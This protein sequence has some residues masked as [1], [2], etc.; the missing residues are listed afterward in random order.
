MLWGASA[1]ASRR[2]G[3]SGCSTPFRRALARAAR[4]APA[5]KSRAQTGRYPSFAAAMAK[6]PEPVPM[7][8]NARPSFREWRHGGFLAIS[9]KQKAVVGCWPV[10]KLNPGSRMTTA[11]FF[12]AFFLLHPGLTSSKSSNS[13][14]LKC[15]FHDSAQSSFRTRP[16]ETLAGP[17]HKATVADSVQPFPEFFGAHSGRSLR[18]YKHQP[19]LCPFR[20]R[21]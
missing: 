15:R 18:E 12:R 11:W 20:S 17:N 16:I 19:G 8:R 4:T 9:L 10:P 1:I 21:K 14:G 3:Q 6:I 13:I 5:S 2:P 7:S